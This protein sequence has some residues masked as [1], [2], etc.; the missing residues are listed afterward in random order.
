MDHSH[1]HT[2]L[3]LASMLADVSE[4]REASDRARQDL[5]AEVQ[6][7]QVE[8]RALEEQLEANQDSM[9]IQS[10]II[11]D[12]REDLRKAEQRLLHPEKMRQAETYQQQKDITQWG[13]TES[14]NAEEEEMSRA[15]GQSEPTCDTV[16][17]GD[18]SY[19]PLPSDTIDDIIEARAIASD[20]DI[21]RC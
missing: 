12:L 19:E 21:P 3:T 16:G 11:S 8:N 18:P 1:K 5:Y 10:G 2:I 4:E 13:L 20:N 7:L 17:D 9:H 6:D 14:K 15:G